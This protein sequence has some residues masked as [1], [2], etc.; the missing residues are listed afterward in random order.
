M[1]E[2]F[3]DC[4]W[5]EQALYN[6]DSR[7]QMLCAY[8]AFR[9]FD[10]SKSVLELM[11]Q[12]VRS[13]GF[14]PICYP[15]GWDRPIPRFNLIYVKQMQ[16]YLEYSGDK[17]FLREKLP[18]LV[19][20]LGKFTERLQQGILPR[21]HKENE[22]FWDFYEWTPTLGGEE[23]EEDFDCALTSFYAYALRAM[24]DI[25]KVLREKELEAYYK[26]RLCITNQALADMFFDTSVGL[27]RTFG[28][29]TRAEYSA[30]V[31]ALCV[32]TGAANLVNGEKIEKAL[33]GEIEKVRPCTLS[34]S[35][36]RYDALL[37]INEKYGEFVLNDLDATY[38]A[39]LQKGATTFWE[40]KF[41]EED[42]GGAG[43]LCHGWS[44][45]PIYYYHRLCENCD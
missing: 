20:L 44:A 37:K 7:N 13:D 5:R 4:P 11:A 12:G 25:C 42:F 36:F 43:S 14:L 6:M 31:N 23:R 32:L 22:T 21:L 35:I 24:T 33:L 17:A 16:E 27:F 28:Q 3:E 38:F 41:G 39:M 34:M 29:E 19:T 30:L 45:I 15:C 10:F 18:F 2:A 8:Y 40:T 1:H 26:E 9:N